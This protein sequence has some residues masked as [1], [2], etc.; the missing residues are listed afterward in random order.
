VAATTQTK[1]AAAQ[2]NHF[3]ASQK[4]RDSNSAR[5]RLHFCLLRQA[6]PDFFKE[7]PASPALCP[8]IS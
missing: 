3:F 7:R 4:N 2:L 5:R 8:F 6:R 1:V